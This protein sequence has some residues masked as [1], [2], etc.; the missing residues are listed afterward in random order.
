[1]NGKE[2][3]MIEIGLFGSVCPL[4]VANFI[5]LS[6]HE[7]GYGYKGSKIH[8]II[9]GHIIVVSSFVH[10]QKVLIPRLN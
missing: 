5:M 3:G 10:D 6:A 4:T 2:L 8:R 7:K 1:M 9:R